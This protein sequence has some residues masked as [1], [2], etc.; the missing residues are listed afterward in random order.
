[1][2]AGYAEMIISGK[3]SDKEQFQRLAFDLMSAHS[4]LN[5][6]NLRERVQDEL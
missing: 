4:S 6:Q 2:A 3:A 1:L 5:G